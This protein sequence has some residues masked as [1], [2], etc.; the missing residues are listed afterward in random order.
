MARNKE[1]DNFALAHYKDIVGE[2][3]NND[4]TAFDTENYDIMRKNFI[5]W[6]QI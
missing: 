6:N 5:I 3:D 2:I 4:T 1:I